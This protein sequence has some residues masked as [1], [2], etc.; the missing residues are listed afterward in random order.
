[1]VV[2]E[3]KPHREDPNQTRITVAGSQICYPVDVGTPTSSLDLIKLVIN[4]FLSRRNARFVCFDLKQFY[5]QTPMERSEYV[6]IKLSDI[7]QEL[8]E[9]YNLTQSVQNEW[10]Y[11]EILHSCYGLPQ[12]GR[13]AN[14]LL[15]TRLEKAGYYEAATTTGVWSH[16][17]RPIQFVLLVDDFGI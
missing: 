2:C 3:V 6:C 15:R 14:D 12:S 13:L 5:L 16:K 1:M 11:F 4:S 7:P 9:E 17:W 8:I 10:I